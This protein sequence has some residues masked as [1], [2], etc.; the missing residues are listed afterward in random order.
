LVPFE[1]TG[2]LSK[3]WVTGELAAAAEFACDNKNEQEKVY[4]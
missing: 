2:M 4:A 3:S 1:S